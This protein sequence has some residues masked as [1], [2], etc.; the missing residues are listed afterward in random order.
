VTERRPS[1][2]NSQLRSCCSW[3]TDFGPDKTVTSHSSSSMNQLGILFTQLSRPLIPSTLLLLKTIL[4][5]SYRLIRNMLFTWVCVCAVFYLLLVSDE[6]V[7]YL[8]MSIKSRLHLLTH[9]RGAWALG[10]LQLFAAVCRSMLTMGGLLPIIVNGR[11]LAPY[12]FISHAFIREHRDRTRANRVDGSVLLL[13]ASSPTPRR[14]TT[15]N[16][17]HRLII[18]RTDYSRLHTPSS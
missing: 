9:C 10:R 7:F 11:L 8:V 5:V 12:A 14:R 6:C 16:I 2:Y 18:S 4:G 3:P 1:I 13:L 17:R 15:F